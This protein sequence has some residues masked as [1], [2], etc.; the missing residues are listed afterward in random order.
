MYE[1]QACM[2]IIDDL[3]SELI[4]EP[5]LNRWIVWPYCCA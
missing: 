1:I 3:I 4:K 5:E 2:V